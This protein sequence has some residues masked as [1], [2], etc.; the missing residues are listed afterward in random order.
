MQSVLVA[1]AFKIF[2]SHS[3]SISNSRPFYV[4]FLDFSHVFSQI[5]LTFFSDFPQVFLR[6]FYRFFSDFFI[7]F[8]QIFLT[9]F[10]DFS[11]VFLRFS[12]RF[13]Q[14]FLLFNGL[15]RGPWARLERSKFH[16]NMRNFFRFTFHTGL[17]LVWGLDLYL[18]AVFQEATENSPFWKDHKQRKTRK[19]KLKA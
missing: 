9:L 4:N 10:S 8:S 19:W 14:I 18:S 12:S 17:F 15:F 6:F 3:R 13:S 11:H 7:V 16:Q 5:L 1:S 2:Q